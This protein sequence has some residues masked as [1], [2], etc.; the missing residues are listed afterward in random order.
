LTDDDKHRIETLFERLDKDGSGDIDKEEAIAAYG[1][2]GLIF[3]NDFDREYEN[4]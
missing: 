2:K 4:H 1:E 3:I